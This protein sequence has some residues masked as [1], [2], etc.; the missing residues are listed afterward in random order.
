MIRSKFHTGIFGLI[1][2]LLAM[3]L[4][5]SCIKEEHSDID[6]PVF[7]GP[8]ELIPA[9]VSGV[10]QNESG[11]PIPNA[12]IRVR[13]AYQ[14]LT[15]D[16]DDQG[17][18]FVPSYLNRGKNAVLEVEAQGK[19][20]TIKQID[21]VR[22]CISNAT[23]RIPKKSQTH[24]FHTNEGAEI[25]LP[26]GM[27]VKITPGAFGDYS[28][29][30]EFY[31]YW[32]T[33][34]NPHFY[35]EEIGGRTAVNQ[36][37]EQIN[38]FSTGVA[39][40]E[41]NTPAGDAIEL[42]DGMTVSLPDHPGLG[43]GNRPHHLYHFNT[44]GW[45]WIEWKRDAVEGSSVTDLV[46]PE[47]GMWSFAHPAGKPVSLSGQLAYM[48]LDQPAIGK[49]EVIFPQ[50][51]DYRFEG[52]SSAVGDFIFSRMPA[53]ES[54]KLLIRDLCGSVV[55]EEEFAPLGESRNLEP[56]EFTLTDT[57]MLELDF[58]YCRAQDMPDEGVIRILVDELQPLVIPF[59]RTQ[60]FYQL[61]NCS[62]WERGTF[63]VIDSEGKVVSKEAEL[64][65]LQ[66][67]LFVEDVFGCFDPNIDMV[68]KYTFT[69]VDDGEIQWQDSLYLI[70]PEDQLQAVFEV[71]DNNEL[72]FLQVVAGAECVDLD[73]EVDFTLPVRTVISKLNLPCLDIDYEINPDK[74]SL[75]PSGLEYTGGEYGLEV[76]ISDL[77]DQLTGDQYNVLI[78][79]LVNPEN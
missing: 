23:I 18:F 70:N 61:P 62:S 12:T 1:A 48:E 7:P 11:E 31:L 44:S 71:N 28:G 15:V 53:N 38:L 32:S 13:T 26:G 51:G 58:G 29:I 4:F 54:F 35:T 20:S 19:F 22:N 45:K 49:V 57:R 55:S 67:E 40:F 63:E 47:S 25:D 8:Q 74:T 9:A 2:V 10:V 14:F 41:F 75:V 69:R 36:E 59:D 24:V 76:S 27:H 79:I 42:Y 77:E 65:F 46:L 39:I 33:P 5:Q 56:V 73:L 21:L 17:A 68:V 64:D 6:N 60:N 52:V 66:S 72:I 3:T 34:E 78:E 16:A 50:L 43:S 37:G 30:V